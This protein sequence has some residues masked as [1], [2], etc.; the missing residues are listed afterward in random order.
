MYKPE[1]LSSV[2]YFSSICF[3]QVLKG[4]SLEHMHTWL[5]KDMQ[6]YKST[7]SA[8]VKQSIRDNGLSS[9][10]FKTYM[11]TKQLK[12][13]HIQ[14]F[15]LLKIAISGLLHDF[16]TEHT[17]IN[18]AVNAAKMHKHSFY[19]TGLINAILR[20]V[21]VN[22]DFWKNQSR[23]QMHTFLPIWWQNTIE[24]D[25][26]IHVEDYIK[27]IQNMPS[28]SLR[29]NAQKCSVADY[30]AHLNASNI[31]AESHNLH[32]KYSPFGICIESAM[33]VHQLPFFEEG[34]VSVQDIAAQIVPQII[35]LQNGM[36]VLDACSAPGGKILSCLEQYALDITLLDIDAQRMQKTQ[37]NIQR[38]QLQTQILN[39]KQHIA[40]ACQLDWWNGEPF[41]VVIADVPCSASGIV[42]K[43]PEIALLRSQAD[44]HNAQQIQAKILANLWH[45]LKKSG[46]LVYISCSVFAQEGQ[47]QIQNFLHLFKDACLLPLPLSHI[48]VSKN[49]DGFFYALLQ[50]ID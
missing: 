37:E 42:R 16:S 3:N 47:Q 15:N 9:H 38:L 6:A 36:K 26:V 45:T 7:I 33:N 21:L 48:S 4:H 27:Y 11:N 35:P 46:I 14:V 44:V 43:Q 41:D 10:V 50:K 20:K 12:N 39:C 18:Q 32:Q 28:M 34:Y 25:K 19:A 5:P 31:V 40:N 22:I 13:V 8:Y 49:H 23:L 2:I 17:L 30:L 1:H 24:Q 29:V